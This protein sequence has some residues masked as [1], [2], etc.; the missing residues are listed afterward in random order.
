MAR[1]PQPGADNGVW[2]DI[3]NDFLEVEHNPDGT[4]KAS[5]TLSTKADDS[6]VVHNTGNE[7]VAGTKTFSS[8]PVVPTPTLGSQAANKTY[9][10]GAVTAGIPDASTSTKGIVQ[11]A[12]DLGGTASSPAVLS[13]NVTKTV[14]ASNADYVTDGTADDV[15]IQ[16]AINAV[17]AAGGGTVFIKAGNYNLTASITINTSNVIIRGD[18]FATRLRFAG[19]TVGT[20]I[21]MADTTQR[22]YIQIR[23]LRISNTGTANTGTAIDMGHFATSR[24]ENVIIDGVNVGITIS[25]ID[26]F[27]NY[28]ENIRVAIGGA[29]AV[30]ILISNGANENTVMR[31]R[32]VTDA[33]STGVVLNN[34]HA[35]GLY[36]VDVET[37]ALIG[38]DVQDSAHD[39]T[40]YSP[41]LESNQTN[42]RIAAGVRST[43]V[44]GG[45]IYGGTTA[46]ITDNGSSGTLWLNPRVAAFPYL[47]T[48]VE[49]IADVGTT[50]GDAVLLD[51]A[52]PAT[53]TTRDSH[54]M[55]WRG[56]YFDTAGH[57][58]DWRQYVNITSTTGGSQMFWKSRTDSSGY[59][60][61]MTLSGNGA[62]TTT[63]K[64]T[65]GG[66]FQSPIATKTASYTLTATDSNILGDATSGA[67][68]ITLPDATNISGLQY[69]VKKIDSSANAVTIA[70]TSS[71]TID[72]ATTKALSSQ[73]DSATFVSDGAN[74]KL[75][76]TSA[77]A[78]GG[79]TLPNIPMPDDQGLLAWAFDPLFTTTS[80]TITNGTVYLAGI[81]MRT[82]G[83]ISKV[84]FIVNTAAVTPT[85]GQNFVGLYNSSGTLLNSTAI[86]NN[87]TTGLHAV[88]LSAA[89]AVTA[90]SYW[91]GLVANA[92]T[93][94]AI[95]RAGAGQL[96]ALNVNL[97]AST[98]RFATNGTSKTSL[99]AI[100]PSSNST[101]GVIAMWVAVS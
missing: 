1:L 68:T 33:S 88:T 61:K 75:F 93:P 60:T 19:Q 38:I 10:D 74:W 85:A 11:L 32:I 62:L 5:G 94:P 7:T 30:G 101:T 81:K 63:N 36:E 92:A 80:T 42:I 31:A 83:T 21:K 50:P 45:Y 55:V 78:S 46:N 97:T 44:I 54:G 96:T 8:S 35:C 82:A 56:T 64:I 17:A 87:L 3:L 70:T 84:Y 99:A 86:D 13:R 100:T 71:Q 90:G 29:G 37:G 77:A 66:A 41:Y 58:V 15:E 98:Y 27:Y 18:G 91:I 39:T 79:A 73:Y 95:S 57:N 59:V 6:S 12:G 16:A 4:L 9:V 67:I 2:G 40:I 22:Q 24:L 69:R 23:D 48:G 28:L 72:G 20:A 14:G 47:K 51:M 65:A 53:S 49:L 34:A 76:S 89:Q 52:Q 26:A 25:T 43:V